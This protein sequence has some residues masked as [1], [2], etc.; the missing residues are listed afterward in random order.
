LLFKLFLIFAPFFERFVE[1]SVCNVSS[2]FF[3][4]T[5]FF[6]ENSSFKS[7]DSDKFRVDVS[8]ILFNQSN[9]NEFS[10]NSKEI[11]FLSENKQNS[12]LT[13]STIYELA[14]LLEV[15]EHLNSVDLKEN[16]SRV[17]VS[18]VGTLEVEFLED[19]ELRS[20]FFAD[21]ASCNICDIQ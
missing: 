16:I 7:F 8:L 3:N 17:N 12:L 11:F 1:R 18:I 4:C 14:V 2:I 19:V 6:Q 13:I 20:V 9:R 21:G 10:K 5:W 15:L